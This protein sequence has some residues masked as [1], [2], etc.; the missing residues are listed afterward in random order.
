MV[1]T[2]IRLYVF[3]YIRIYM[4]TYTHVHV[5]VY[6]C[7]YDSSTTCLPPHAY[8][9]SH[10]SSS[11]RGAVT[12]LPCRRRRAQP[13]RAAWADLACC[14]RAPALSGKPRPWP[15]GLRPCRVCCPAS[16]FSRPPRALDGRRRLAA[17][18]P[19]IQLRTNSILAAVQT[20]GLTALALARPWSWS[21]RLRPWR[22]PFLRCPPSGAAAR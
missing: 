22:G 15:G 4:Y 8:V 16:P 9:R 2:Y 5:H 17:C 21:G 7:I 19:L 14:T 3:T 20:L 11:N 10:C 1:F 13:A 12:T 6:T 18:L